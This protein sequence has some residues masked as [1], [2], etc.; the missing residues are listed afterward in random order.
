MRVLA[1]LAA[2]TLIAALPATDEV[3]FA[4]AAV[5]VAVVVMTRRRVVA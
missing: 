5:F 4:L 1:V 2:V 3:G